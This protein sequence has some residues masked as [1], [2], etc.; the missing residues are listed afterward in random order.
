MLLHESGQSW[1][2]EVSLHLKRGK[3]SKE[4]Q[5]EH[6]LLLEEGFDE[7]SRVQSQTEDRSGLK[8]QGFG[9]TS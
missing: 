7:N 9:A 4:S 2:S 1:E 6:V 3:V 5:K 8:S